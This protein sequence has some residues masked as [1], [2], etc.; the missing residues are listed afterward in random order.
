[1]TEL[2]TTE[3]NISDDQADQGRGGLAEGVGDADH[4][5]KVED[6]GSNEDRRQSPGGFFAE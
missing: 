1:M 6:G 2:I 4:F 3:H 5:V